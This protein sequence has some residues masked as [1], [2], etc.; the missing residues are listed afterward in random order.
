MPTENE[1]KYVLRLN[2]ETM[3]CEMAK[4]H[5]RIHQG[6]MM[7]SKGMSLRLRKCQEGKVVIPRLPAPCPL[8]LEQAGE[9]PKHYMTFKCSCNGG[10]N[11]VVEIEKKIDERDFN[12]LWPQ[13]MNKLTKLR[14]VVRDEK[15]QVWEIDFF[16]THDNTNYFALAEF[17]MPEG[18]TAPDFMPSFIKSNMLHEVSLTDCR[19]SSKLLG[20]VRYASDLYQ[21]L[22]DKNN[23]VS[24]RSG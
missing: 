3:M 24:L 2:C 18:Q 12:D 7:A 4:N 21:S 8:F 10:A 11:R 6:Y 16:K 19:F 20:D 22:E 15:K 1:R 23:G 9:K 13:C 5:L 17:E 14:Y